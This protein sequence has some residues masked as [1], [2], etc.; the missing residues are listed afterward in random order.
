MDELKRASPG[1]FRCLERRLRDPELKLVCR[2]WDDT[3]LP[4]EHPSVNRR[5][6]A[7]FNPWPARVVY[8]L[9]SECSENDTTVL[10]GALGCL[11]LKMKLGLPDAMPL[12]SRDLSHQ[13]LAWPETA[14]SDLAAERIAGAILLD[15]LRHLHMSKYS[16][17]HRLAFLQNVRERVVPRLAF[18]E[19]AALRKLISA[20]V[21]RQMRLVS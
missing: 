10:L 8:I 18:E 9:V 6:G 16:P 12:E 7:S 21:E 4:P 15:E 13:A 19:N 5:E 14:A 17:E 11:A 1:T 2:V 20:A 3:A